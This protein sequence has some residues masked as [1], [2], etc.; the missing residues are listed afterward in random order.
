MACV[1]FRCYCCTWPRAGSLE[2]AAKWSESPALGGRVS[3]VFFAVQSTHPLTTH[4]FTTLDPRRRAQVPPD[5]ST[6]G[7]AVY[8]GEEWQDVCVGGFIV[9]VGL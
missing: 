8:G 9:Q 6:S 5:A 1:A 3:L 4:H 2:P 7:G